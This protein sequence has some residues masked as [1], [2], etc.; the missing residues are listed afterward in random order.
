MLFLLDS[1]ILIL[2]MDTLLFFLDTLFLTMDILLLLLDIH[3]DHAFVSEPQKGFNV[4]INK[5]RAQKSCDTNL[6]NL[7]YINDNAK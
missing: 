1:D 7:N 4:I 6:L 3:E 2:A 5:A